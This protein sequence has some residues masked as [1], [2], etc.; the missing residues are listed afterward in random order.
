MFETEA[1]H[2]AA[3]FGAMK[4]FASEMMHECHTT[5]ASYSAHSS[6]AYGRVW[7]LSFASQ[8]TRD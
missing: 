4:T 3:I 7:I 8:R 2:D 5:N 1:R 6:R